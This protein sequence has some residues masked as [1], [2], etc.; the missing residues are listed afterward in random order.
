TWQPTKNL[1]HR[2]RVP[3]GPSLDHEYWAPDLVE[4]F[5]HCSHSPERAV[6]QVLR[7]RCPPGDTA[8]EPLLPHFLPAVTPDFRVGRREVSGRHERRV[9]LVDVVARRP[10]RVGPVSVRVV[11][12]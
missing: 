11:R 6:V 3:I 1:E 2:G 8:F 5:P 9:H 7:E 12:S 10:T 4:L